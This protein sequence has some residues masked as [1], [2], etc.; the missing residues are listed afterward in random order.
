V[1]PCGT[2]RRVQREPKHDFTLDCLILPYAAACLQ[3]AS[4][5]VT[6]RMP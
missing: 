3:R 1:T 5:L 6:K 4:T 2:R